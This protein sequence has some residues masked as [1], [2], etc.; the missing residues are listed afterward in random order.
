[1]FELDGTIVAFTPTGDSHCRLWETTVG[2]NAIHISCVTPV[3]TPLLH[4]A[5]LINLDINGIK[6]SYRSMKN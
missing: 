2:V 5:E 3:G 4:G 1:M 6:I